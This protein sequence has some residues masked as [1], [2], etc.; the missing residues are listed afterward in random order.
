VGLV[1][2]TGSGKTSLIN[3]LVRFYEPTKGQILLDSVDLR[4]YPLDL[5]RSQFALVLQEPVLFSTTI[6]KNIAYGN[7][8]TTHQQI[9][10][11]AIAANAHEFIMSLPNRYETEVGERGSMLSGGERQRVSLARAFLKDAPILIL[12]EPTSALDRE[13]EAEILQ[14]MRRLMQGRT[15]FF[16][17]HRLKALSNCDVL[18]KIR[19]GRLIQLPVPNSPAEIDALL[20][21]DLQNAVEAELA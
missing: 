18:L 12:D 14:T 1:G 3:M 16:I 15:C 6:A 2:R 10:Q 4:D 11:A 7:P 8:S 19:N 20:V 9:V 21:E 5:L 17:S 13:T